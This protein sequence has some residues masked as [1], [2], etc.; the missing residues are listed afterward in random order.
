MK[1]VKENT[2]VTNVKDMKFL[3]LMLVIWIL[4]YGNADATI[5]E[6]CNKNFES[7]GR[8]IWRCKARSLH[9]VN[10]GIEN[11][12][13]ERLSTSS[14]HG[15]RV[16]ESPEVSLVNNNNQIPPTK[17]PPE[18]RDENTD[19]NENNTEENND[20]AVHNN[21]LKCFCGKKC[22]GLRGL[23]SHKRACKVLTIPDLKSFVHGSSTVH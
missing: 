11:Q 10:P 14:N 4:N 22:K 12:L 16:I 1:Q 6:F 2:R 21:Y 17:Y 3:F 5:C 19:E 8:H 20:D 15:N 18:N 9:T 23:Q 7:L 13:A